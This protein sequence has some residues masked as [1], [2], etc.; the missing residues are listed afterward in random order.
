MPNFK[1]E[2]KN[3][4]GKAVTGTIVGT[5]QDAAVAELRKRNLIVLSVRPAAAGGGAGGAVKS[6]LTSANPNHF[7][8]RGDE[9]VVFTR[10]LATMVGA[11]IPLLESLEILQE[12]AE[13]PGFAAVLDDVVEQIRSGSDLST[14]LSRFPKTFSNIYTSMVKA[15]EVSG[16]LDEILTRLAEYL[17]A[18][19]KLKRDIR[20]AM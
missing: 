2:A 6:L 12:Q 7:R 1:Y 8:P 16:Q 11:G 13:R 14:G 9:L 4:G 3:F 10:Q 19:L 18:S 20:A 5:S 15:G 17:E